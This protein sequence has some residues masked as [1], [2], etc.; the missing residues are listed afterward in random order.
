MQ[1]YE[2]IKEIRDGKLNNVVI[3]VYKGTNK[4]T[5]IRVVDGGLKWET[6][7]FNT[8]LLTEADVDFRVVDFRVVEKPKGWFKPEEGEGYWC[9][10]QLE[11]F[12]NYFWAND[13][14]DNYL[15]ESHNCFRSKEEAI[16]YRDYKKALRETEKPF[17]VDKDNWSIVF[18]SHNKSLHA[19][20]NTVMQRQ[21]TVY[22]GQDRKVA[23][24]F[25]D[26]WKEQILKFEFNMW[27]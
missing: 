19:D 3:E 16:E 8:S 14:T 24:A 22:L 2:L 9:V 18:D 17:E 12:N 5:E 25:I 6:G 13:N 15:Y 21:G 4:H 7:R 11:K 10:V 20:W 27:E 26:K 23:Q 1:G